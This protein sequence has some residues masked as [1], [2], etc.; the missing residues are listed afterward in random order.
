M[1]DQRTELEE[2]RR[3]DE[4]EAKSQN[5]GTPNLMGKLADMVTGGGYSKLDAKWGAHDR[6]THEK[7]EKFKAEN[8]NPSDHWMP[9]DAIAP[10]MTGLAAAIQGGASKMAGAVSTP[11]GEAAIGLASPRTKHA[12]DLV[13]ALAGGAA[14]SEAVK[15]AGPKLARRGDL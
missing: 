11:V 10:P 14:G 9:V 4:L 5:M 2:L 12:M 3:I 13:K 6:D 7:L 8:P 1:S 15:W